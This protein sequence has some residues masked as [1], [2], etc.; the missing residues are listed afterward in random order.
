MK[1][2]LSIFLLVAGF[3]T[4]LSFLVAFAA[5]LVLQFHIDPG[6]SAASRRDPRSIF[7]PADCYSSGA[8][9]FWKIRDR[10]FKT[11]AIACAVFALLALLTNVF[12][13]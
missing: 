7:S 3:V 4:F 2:A 12:P 5:H 9:G 8:R 6:G 11:F 10:S 1:S 13:L